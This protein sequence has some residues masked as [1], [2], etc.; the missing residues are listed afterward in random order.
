MQSSCVH[1]DPVHLRFCFLLKERKDKIQK[2]LAPPPPVATRLGTLSSLMLRFDFLGVHGIVPLFPA[3]IHI[4]PSENASV[5]IIPCSSRQAYC[6][7]CICNLRCECVWFHFL[8][9]FLFRVALR[10]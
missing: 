1:P 4:F 7:F 6:L 5:L 10:C 9:A 8:F 2:L 3:V